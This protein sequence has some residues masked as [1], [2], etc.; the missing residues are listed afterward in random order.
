MES[1]H[2][3]QNIHTAFT[4]LECTLSGLI[5]TYGFGETYCTIFCLED[6]GVES[7]KYWYLAIIQPC[8]TSPRAV[9]LRAG[10]AMVVWTEL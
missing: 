6:A 9:I 8:I 2:S 3:R 7:L 1:W 5:A 4:C 10:D